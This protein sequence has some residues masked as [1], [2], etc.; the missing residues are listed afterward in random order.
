MDFISTRSADVRTDAPGAV[1]QGLAADGGLFVPESIPSFAPDE[2][3][4]MADMEYPVLAASVLARFLPGFDAGELLSF[5]KKA[6]DSFDD[7]AV[8]PLRRLDNGLPF[9]IEP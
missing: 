7:P 9:F 8:A 1:I 3:T 5:A 6:Y 4:A 2:I